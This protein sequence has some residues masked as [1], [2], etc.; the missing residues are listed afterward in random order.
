M[1]HGKI[2]RLSNFSVMDANPITS[3]GLNMDGN[4]TPLREWMKNR[5]NEPSIENRKMNR[6]RLS[7]KYRLKKRLKSEQSK[8]S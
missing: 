4:N 8:R 7:I 1:I 5:R 3:D 2:G 6:K